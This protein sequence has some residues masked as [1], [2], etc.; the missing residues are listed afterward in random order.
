MMNGTVAEGDPGAAAMIDTGPE[1][2]PMSAVLGGLRAP[3]SELLATWFYYTDCKFNKNFQL[4]SVVLEGKISA[5]AKL[6][7]IS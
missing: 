1:A 3:E 4:T 5:V 6:S 2:P 7:F